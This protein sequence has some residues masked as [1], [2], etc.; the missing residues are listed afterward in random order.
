MISYLQKIPDEIH[1][2]I[3]KFISPVSKPIIE[4]F[5]PNYTWWCYKCGDY[6]SP[7]QFC[8]KAE[9]YS[10]NYICLDCYNTSQ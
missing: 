7:N 6:I 2:Y 4:R 1:L 10:S 8:V 3:Y 9:T 5:I